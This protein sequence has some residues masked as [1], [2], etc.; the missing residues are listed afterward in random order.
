MQQISYFKLLS[1]HPR[2]EKKKKVNNKH[3]QHHRC[4]IAY[5]KRLQIKQRKIEKS[6][7][8]L[9]YPQT[10]GNDILRKMKQKKK[11]QRNRFEGT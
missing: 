10:S 1:N 8:I 9:N 2:L 3:K 6:S 7:H 5:M 11:S 4:K